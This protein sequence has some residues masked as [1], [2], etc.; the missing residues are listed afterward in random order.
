M[1][2]AQFAIPIT[3]KY[4][5]FARSTK[6]QTTSHQGPAFFFT[7]HS[8]IRVSLIRT[9]FKSFEYEATNRNHP[10]PFIPRLPLAVLFR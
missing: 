4:A 7:V 1:R 3:E 9:R 8:R 5:Y 2:F 10:L 6:F